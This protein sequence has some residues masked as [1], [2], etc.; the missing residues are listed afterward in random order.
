MF[1]LLTYR[2]N[3]NLQTFI[4]KANSLLDA[5]TDVE[6]GIEEPYWLVSA[7]ASLTNIENVF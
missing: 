1:F 4:R 2:V 7:Y 6:K 3:G 5:R